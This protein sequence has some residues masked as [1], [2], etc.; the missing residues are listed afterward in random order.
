MPEAT[1]TAS[2][3][4]RLT[5]PFLVL[6]YPVTFLLY[7]GGRYCGPV[8]FEPTPTGFAAVAGTLIA[9]G[10]VAAGIALGLRR[11]VEQ[12]DSTAVRPLIT[13]SRWASILLLSVF[14]G[15][16]LFLTLD[17]VAL[18]EAVWK[19]IVLPLSFV[20]FLPV[21]L[22]YG[23]TFPLAVLFSI[24]GVEPS[25]IITVLTRSVV[26]AVGFPLSAVMQTYLVDLV[27]RWQTGDE[28]PMEAA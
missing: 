1:T 9:L 18:Y 17:A 2:Q 3:S 14:G 23:L 13:P 26:L 5:L 10:I 4:W 15:F 28:N 11:I 20:L 24:A 7:Q 8:C 6:A 27:V 22:L 25:P 12:S 19:P 16:V 21:W